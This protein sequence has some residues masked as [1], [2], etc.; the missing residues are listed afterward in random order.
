MSCRPDRFVRPTD[1]ATPLEP[2]AKMPPEKLADQSFPT[3]RLTYRGTEYH[4]PT[5]RIRA[6]RPF[7]PWQILPYP[8]S[9]LCHSAQHTRQSS[10][11]R[12]ACATCFSSR[13]V[14]L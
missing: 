6:A 1:S 11:Y 4:L 3:H 5:P 12:S 7:S 13:G 9:L 2:N 8:P 10:K 14:D